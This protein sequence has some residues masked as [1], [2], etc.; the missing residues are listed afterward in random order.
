MRRGEEEDREV[1]SSLGVDA[2]ASPK[3]GERCSCVSGVVKTRGN[4]GEGGD[5]RAKGEGGTRTMKRRG[6]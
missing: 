6:L 2:V 4:T 3:R 5:P 1:C